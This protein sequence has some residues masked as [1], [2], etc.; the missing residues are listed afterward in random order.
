MTLGFAFGRS[1]A[2][3]IGNRHRVTDAGGLREIKDKLDRGRYLSHHPEA[4]GDMAWLLE[5]LDKREAHI[6]RLEERL[7][8]KDWILSLP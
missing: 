2:P 6:A 5:Q 3:N 1:L 4:E 7:E 8:K